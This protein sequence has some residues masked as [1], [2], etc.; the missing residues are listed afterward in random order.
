MADMLTDRD[1]HDALARPR[2]RFVVHDIARRTPIRARRPAPTAPVTSMAPLSPS[3]NATVVDVIAD[4]RPMFEAEGGNIEFVDVRGCV[5]RVRLGGA[6]VDCGA[7]PLSLVRVEHHLRLALGR[8][9]PVLPI[10][11]AEEARP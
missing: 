8:R 5:V 2:P 1:A 4:M 11:S 6:C 9:V 3:E 10:N 7:A